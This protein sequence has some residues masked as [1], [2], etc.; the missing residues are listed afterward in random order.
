ML[1]WTSGVPEHT[2]EVAPERDRCQHWTVEIGGR[3]GGR[4]AACLEAEPRDLQTPQEE[5]GGWR[6][7]CIRSAVVV[8]QVALGRRCPEQG[9]LLVQLL[10]WGSLRGKG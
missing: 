9:R 8:A 6:G 10:G 5:R 2:R 1:T 4:A 7:C 3:G